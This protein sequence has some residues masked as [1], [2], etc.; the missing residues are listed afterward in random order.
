MRTITIGDKGDCV[1]AWQRVVGAAAD[2]TFGVATEN[3]VKSWQTSRGVEADGVIGPR[4][5]AALEP[6]DLI[7]PHEGFRTKPYDDK[8]GTTVVL[9][10][11]VWRRPDGAACI[12]NPTIGWG[13]RIWPGETITSCTLEEGNQWFA[14]R[15]NAT[16]MPAVRRAGLK[17]AEQICAAASFAY[18]CGTGALA[19][20]AKDWTKWCDY[21]KSGGVV[22]ARLVARRAEEYAMFSGGDE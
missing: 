14:D 9:I 15:L 22:D 19:K 12:G 10:S 8:D 16:E 1:R 3:K 4:T 17:Y 5:W 7:K 11:G 18:N 20:L 21:V 2:G 13:R 6:G